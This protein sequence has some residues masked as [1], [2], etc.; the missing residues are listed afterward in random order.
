[1]KKENIDPRQRLLDAAIALLAEVK[2]PDSLTVRQ[3]A[4]R[5]RVG[6][7]L[8]N[9]HFGSKEQLLDQA[10][11]ELMQRDAGLKPAKART[12]AEGKP[13]ERVRSILKQTSKVGLRFP[14]LTRML[15]KRALLGGDY[16]PERI[17][18]PLLREHF[19]AGLSEPEIRVTAI[20][21]V[22]P[23]QAMAARAGDFETFTGLDFLDEAVLDRIID[24][25]VDNILKH[26][27]GG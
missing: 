5:A 27:E 17:L 2:D 7:G 8:L 24:R 21:I 11:A 22:A 19:G 14:S 4:D 20:Q 3:I 9:Y 6:V 1:M 15:A 26:P 10:I 25:L 18:L 13:L 12:G 16:G 23:L